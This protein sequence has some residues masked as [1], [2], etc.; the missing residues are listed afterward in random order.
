MDDGSR[1]GIKWLGIEAQADDISHSP[2]LPISQSPNIRGEVTGW[3]LLS[4]F[5][6]RNGRS[7]AMVLLHRVCS[8]S[9]I[10]FLDCGR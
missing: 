4:S 10:F 2:I 6:K 1:S 5:V 7:A 8:R 3:K 9:R